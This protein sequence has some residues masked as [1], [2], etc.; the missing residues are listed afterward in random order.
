[1]RKISEYAHEAF[2]NNRKFNSVNTKVKIEDGDTNM[3]LFGKHIVKKTNNDLYI[4]DGNY[5]ATRT[6]QDRLN[7]FPGVHLRISKGEWIL[8]EKQK[9]DGQWININNI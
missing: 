5:R 6:T 7:T 9:W 8:N 1:M 2:I 3:Y 4:S